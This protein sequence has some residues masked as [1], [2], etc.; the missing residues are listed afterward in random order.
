MKLVEK[1]E[2]VRAIVLLIFEL[3]IPTQLLSN[4]RA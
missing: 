4:S 3:R 2:L 1:S